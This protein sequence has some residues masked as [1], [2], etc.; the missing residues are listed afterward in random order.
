MRR[1]LL[2]LGVAL[3][4]WPAPLWAQQVTLST[5]LDYESI[6]QGFRDP[7]RYFHV[8]GFLPRVNLSLTGRVRPGSR[9]YLDVTG[10]LSRN[11]FGLSH[12]AADNAHF[13]LRQEAPRFRLSLRQGATHYSTSAD[14]L[15]AGASPLT[16]DTQ[17]TGVTMVLRKPS[18]PVLNLHYARVAADSDLGGAAAHTEATAR[19]VAATYDLRPFRLRYSENR[20]TGGAREGPDFAFGTRRAGVS[21]DTA[22]SPKL[23]LYGD[24]SLAHAEARTGAAA[25]TGSDQRLGS[26]H[27]STELTPKV[28][29][30][31]QLFSRRT[32]PFPR[33][34]RGDSAAR[35]A[36]LEMRSEVLPGLQL[37][38]SQNV[39]HSEYGS[40][41]TEV[42]STTADLLARLDGRNSLALSLSPSRAHFSDAPDLTQRAYR[43]SWT[44]QLDAQTSLVAS[45]DRFA[46]TGVSFDNRTE[47]QYLA[48]RYRPD[49]QTTLGLGLQRDTRRTRG[50]EGPTSQQAHALEAEFSWLPTSNLSLGCHL[51][52]NRVSGASEVRAKVPAFDLRW[53]PDSRSD[54]SLSWRLPREV[55][56]ENDLTRRL[57]LSAFSGQFSRR[58]SRRASLNVHYDVLTFSQGPFAYERRLG[59]SLTTGLGR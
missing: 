42:A 51:S 28:A 16:S 2:A 36:S 6:D 17:E 29:L 24:L 45:L 33:A 47:S 18:W 11:T 44:S 40:R 39:L 7:E 31:A 12:Q 50:P 55:D 8:S 14:D 26:L 3:L 46:D 15:T 4:C 27:L 23:T 32:D 30:D 53:Q 59:L 56:R 20:R 34:A 49:L 57:G 9:L 58:L 5:Q 54:L 10:G 13:V 37:N 19:L 48:V 52:L 41:R 38:L 43:L 25:A 21:F 1:G 22:L 35:G